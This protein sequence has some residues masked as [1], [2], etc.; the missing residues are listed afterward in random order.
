MKYPR[1]YHFSFSP[2]IHSDDKRMNIKD[3]HNLLRDSYVISE[4][5][6]GG[7]MAM[8]VDYIH[9]RSDSGQL[10]ETFDFVK[11]NHYY[12][13]KHFFNEDYVYYGEN[14]YAMH[15]IYYDALQ[16]YFYLF[17]ILNRKSNTWLAY[18][19]VVKESKRLEFV[20]PRE[21]GIRKNPHKFLKND[22]V[23][24][25][26]KNLEPN[27]EGYV[28]RN[29]NSFHNDDFQKNVAK[30]VRKGHVQTDEHW[31]KNWVPNKLTAYNKYVVPSEL[32]FS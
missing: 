14:M 22:F 31:S 21:F 15:S 24:Y 10:D 32:P 1:T 13:K 19:D 27:M 12:A 6:D 11:A 23:S 30:Y 18:E 28:I 16:D 3:E 29:I 20:M 2:E 7:N 17:G 4:K 9:A 25:L 8:S 26:E 5:M